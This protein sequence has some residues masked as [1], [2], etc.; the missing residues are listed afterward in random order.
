MSLALSACSGGGGSGNATQTP[1][2]IAA[3]PQPQ[4]Q[5]V[6]VDD[7]SSAEL[8]V[9]ATGTGT[10]SYQWRL[11]GAD[12]A[13]ATSS[14]LLTPA[15]TLADSGAAYSVV[16]SSGGARIVSADAVVTVTALP[17]TWQAQ[18]ASTAVVAGQSAEFTA[19]ATGSQPIGYQWKRNGADIADATAATYT[20]PA[21]AL[22]D[23]GAR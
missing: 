5:P 22:S 19:G 14:T 4:P 16:V 3:Q 15:L 1:P 17:L 6:T 11:N 21:T 2:T 9:E 12:I 7:G 20:T 18:P 8:S 10:L 23:D 13:D